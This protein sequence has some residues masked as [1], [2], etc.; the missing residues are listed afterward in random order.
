MSW[1]MQVWNGGFQ[2]LTFTG[3]IMKFVMFRVVTD[4][5]QSTLHHA[6]GWMLC[7]VLWRAFWQR[8]PFTTHLSTS[9]CLTSLIT[10]LKLWLIM[11]WLFTMLALG[12]QNT[13][14][15]ILLWAQGC[16][17]TWE[18][19]GKMSWTCWLR[20]ATRYR[21]KLRKEHAAWFLRFAFYFIAC[22]FAD[23]FAI[24]GCDLC[25]WFAWVCCKSPVHV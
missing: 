8:R 14:P 5:A 22:M 10:V 3:W 4:H 2:T 18:N 15:Y 13:H 25:W 11:T 7:Q 16:C 23:V 24:S 1:I 20:R 6:L 21:L 17:A 19:S 9:L 12:G